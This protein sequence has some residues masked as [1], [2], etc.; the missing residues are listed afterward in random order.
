MGKLRVFSGP[1]LRKLLEQYGF[2]RVRQ[3][4][5]HC[6]MQKLTVEGHTVTVPIPLHSV[7]RRGT[8]LSIIR[9]SGIPKQEFELR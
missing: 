9:Q 5:S 4:G 6:M 2:R 3:Q 7:I 8:L 1:E